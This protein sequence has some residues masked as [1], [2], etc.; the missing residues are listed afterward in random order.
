MNGFSLVELM[1]SLSLGLALSGVMLQ[2]LMADGQSS[3]RFSL[4]LRERAVQRRTLELVKG[5]LAQATA[6]S[7]TPELE[8]HACSLAGRTPVLHVTTTGGP[9]TYSV[10][11]PP[12]AIWHGQVLMRCGPAFGLDGTIN[13]G[14]QYFNRVVIDNLAVAPNSG[15]KCSAGTDKENA[16][17]S[18][19]LATAGMPFS[20]CKV[21]DY[22]LILIEIVRRIGF[23]AKT[24]SVSSS[25]LTL[26]ISGLD[27]IR[28]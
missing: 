21:Q 4:L 28:R 26:D 11:A 12:S 8:R 9:I 6:I 10:G 7:T 25:S 19:L 14:T 17:L 23:G 3:G 2:G 18:R 24:A 27:Y 20:V 13:S 15:S 1:L 16:P 22:E 5:D